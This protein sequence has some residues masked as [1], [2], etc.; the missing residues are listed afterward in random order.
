MRKGLKF[1]LFLP[2]LAPF[3]SSCSVF[4]CSPN[5]THVSPSLL[6]S[7]LFYFEFSLTVS[8]CCDD[9]GSI[10]GS[11]L[12][13][14]Y[15]GKKKV[16]RELSVVLL[17]LVSPL[18]LHILSPRDTDYLLFCRGQCRDSRGFSEKNGVSEKNHR[19]RK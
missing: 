13:L 5:F 7:S 11:S 18:F 17:F 6:L 2:L 10:R 4:L 12:R 1:W 8:S 9:L 15:V 14:A 3:S 16:G 19:E